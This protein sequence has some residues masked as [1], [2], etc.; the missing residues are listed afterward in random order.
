MDFQ[1]PQY[2]CDFMT[3][4]LLKD[5]YN[6]ILEPTPGLGNLVS[7]VSRKADVVIAPTNFFNIDFNDKYDAVI[8]NPPF[9]PMK[10]GYEIL[11]KCMELSNE[12]VA[13]MPWLTIIN[14]TKRTQ[15][16]FGF[17]LLSVTH[18]PRSV[19]DGSRVQ[20]CIL[21]LNKDHQGLTKFNMFKK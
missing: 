6:K 3:E 15:N 17:G 16:I 2:V 9:T 19:F 13:L 1:T 4:L 7:S 21:H 10:T 12:I 14:S 18:L 5:R 8:M 11:F 20:C